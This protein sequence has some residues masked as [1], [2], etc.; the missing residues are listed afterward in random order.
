[1]DEIMNEAMVEEVEKKSTPKKT[2]T[3]KITEEVTT[4]EPRK[5]GPNDTIMCHSIF[6]GTFLF[7]GPKSKIVYPFEAPG[8]ENPVEYQDL[9]AAM[10]SKKK[11][12]MAPYI[13]IDDEELLED[14]KWKQVKKI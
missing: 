2:T 8:D 10:M 4:K 12:I 14:F 6:P 3:K 11:S 13:V 9:L 1:M 5:Y 7:S